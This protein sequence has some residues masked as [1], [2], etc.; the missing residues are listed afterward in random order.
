MNEQEG[1]TETIIDGQWPPL[2]CDFTC[3]PSSLTFV[4]VNNDNIINNDTTEKQKNAVWAPGDAVGWCP[5]VFV[6]ISK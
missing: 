2:A 4:I 6:G 3:C 1:T 5:T